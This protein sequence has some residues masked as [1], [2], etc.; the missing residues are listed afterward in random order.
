MVPRIKNNAPAGF[1]GHLKGILERVV[2]MKK[3]RKKGEE[4][5]TKVEEEENVV[6][7]RIIDGRLA[8]AGRDPP[9]SNWLKDLEERDV[10]VAEDKTSADYLQ[11]TFE[12]ISKHP[13]TFELMFTNPKGEEFY[14]DVNPVRFCQKYNLVLYRGKNVD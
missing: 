7:F 9:S 5:E 1:L 14:I 4:T 2:P 11:Q 3:T 8:T 10:F 13:L 12:I 6:P